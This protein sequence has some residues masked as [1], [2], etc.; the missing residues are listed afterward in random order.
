[1]FDGFCILLKWN[2]PTLIFSLLFSFLFGYCG[3]GA[4]SFLFPKT[5][6]LTVKNMQLA[7]SICRNEIL[8]IMVVWSD[9]NIFSYI[10]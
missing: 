3:A 6:V 7:S 4:P 10:Q 2:L 1:M 5:Y 8:R 9:I